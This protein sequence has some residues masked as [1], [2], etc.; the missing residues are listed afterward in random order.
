MPT[1]PF[2]IDAELLRELGERLVGKPHIALA[3]LVKNSYDADATQVTINFTP[4]K[5]KIEISDDGHGMNLDE[6]KKFWMRIGT[7]H[8]REKRS[9]NLGR[10]MTGS[11]GVGRLAV[12][13][14]ANKLTILTIPA[15][16]NSKGLKVHIDWKKAIGTKRT[17]TKELT[18]VKVTYN[19]VDRNPSD[20]GTSVILEEL[21]DEWTE[22]SVKE[23]ASELW[24][25]QPPLNLSTEDLKNRFKIHFRSTLQ[26][27]S[28][29]FLEQM[30]AIKRIWLARLVGNTEDGEVKFSLQ[31]PGE[32]PTV[33]RCKIADFIHNNGKFNKKENLNM[34]QFEIRIYNLSGKQKFGIKVGEA[35]AYFKN[36][37]GVHVYDGGF[38]LPYYGSPESDWLKL[39]YDH[40]HRQYVSQ[41]LPKEIQVFRALYD[42]PT[43]GRVLGVV[44]VDTSQ[45][46]NLEIMI[47]RDRLAE[48]TAYKDLVT[49]VR[50]ALDWYANETARRKIQKKEASSEPT[51]LTFEYVEEVLEY[52]KPDIPEKIYQ[53]I[54]EKVQEATTAAKTQQELA[55]K[56]V[57]LLTS[58]ATAGISALSYQH[59]LK[60]Q[61]AYIEDLIDRMKNI[62]TMRSELQENLNSLST[63]LALWLK[64]AKATNLLFDYIADTENTQ[65]RHSLRAR[66]VV[67]DITD[68]TSF[69]ARDTEIDY[70]QI[71]KY[72]RLPKASFAEW[73]A[74]FQNVFINAFNA[75]LDSPK[76]LLHISCRSRGKS[77]EILIQDTGHGINLKDADR[78]FEPF[79]RESKISDARKALGYGGTGLG[80]TIIRLL[81][82]NIGCRVRFVEPEDGFSTAFSI[83]W[84][85][86]K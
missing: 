35:R 79:E 16:K 20:K 46:P 62:R 5:D 65:L 73:G 24:W 57:G 86:I 68:Q 75:M 30:S 44:E 40:S 43:L 59:E 23:L 19:E 17:K 66:M 70:S 58:L 82:N 22:D 47:T 39:E 60:K 1:L 77:R 36:H 25:L 28:K 10:L 54:Y 41:L 80:L 71:D 3:E 56:Q 51:S 50:Y 78:L 67:E 72:L 42:L 63:E 15:D 83:S 33:H 2:T 31:F 76:P 34:C 14:L 81:A 26:E 21:K 13:F 4:N 53:E 7:T 32:G 27:Y 69:L 64:R 6:F 8:K 37:G 85:E 38:R 12:Q 11:K 45:E 9:K 74:I 84:R 29:R 49:T 18:E 55:L 52:Y 48:T 61:F